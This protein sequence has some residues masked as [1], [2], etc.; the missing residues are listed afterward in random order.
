MRSRLLP[1]ATLFLPLALSLAHAQ[2]ITPPSPTSVPTSVP[3]DIVQ[4]ATDFAEKYLL[5]PEALLVDV[6]CYPDP[7]KDTGLYACTAPVHP[8]ITN[9]LADFVCSVKGCFRL[10]GSVLPSVPAPSTPTK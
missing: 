7:L 9:T 3:K 1:L 8:G 2:T 10:L 5:L 4:H 6:G